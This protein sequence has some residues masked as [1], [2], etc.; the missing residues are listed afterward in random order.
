MGANAKEFLSIRMNH[1]DELFNSDYNQISKIES[2]LKTAILT[3]MELD[4]YWR[5]LKGNISEDR[6]YEIIEY[7]Y[8]NQV[9]PIAAGHNYSQSQIKKKNEL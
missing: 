2:L 7:L 4:E 6:A 8:K 5:E 3:P 9:D 1:I